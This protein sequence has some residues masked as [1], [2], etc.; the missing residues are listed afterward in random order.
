MAAAGTTTPTAL[1]ADLVAWLEGTTLTS[2]VLDRPFWHQD[3]LEQSE[4]DHPRSFGLIP[5]SG[6]SRKPTSGFEWETEYDFIA[7]YPTGAGFSVVVL[8]DSKAVYLRLS[9]V[10]QNIDG[11]INIVV[12]DDADI[13]T[14]GG[15]TY[16]TR[17]FSIRY[18]DP[19]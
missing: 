18:T 15:A 3:E 12:D 2:D 9:E 19:N 14:D 16:L 17:R 4:N 6:P 5:R 13:S 10:I 7:A 11:V 8:E 1:H